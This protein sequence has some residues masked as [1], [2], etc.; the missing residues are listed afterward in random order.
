[1]LKYFALTAV[2]LQIQI[3][4][5]YANNSDIHKGLKDEQS[6]QLNFQKLKQGKISSQAKFYY[7]QA[8]NKYLNKDYK[9]AILNYTQAIKINP[10][11][12]D[13]YTGRG[14]AYR[15]LQDYQK[16]ILDCTQ[17]IKINPNYADAY[18]DRGSVFVLL[19]NYQKGMNDLNQAIKINPNDGLAYFYR[20]NARAALGD[21]QGFTEDADKSINI[22]T[23]TTHNLSGEIN[24]RMGRYEVAITEYN[25]AIEIDPNYAEAYYNR[26]QSSEKLGDYKGAVADYNQAANFFLEQG[27]MENHKKALQN[28]K[29]IQGR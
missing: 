22:K 10:N 29:R 12:A 19:K 24:F 14:L 21:F 25:Q 17:A 27:D 4:S 26:G 6:Y 9:G 28:I 1:M 15:S 5:V 16:A 11:Y 3:G 13:A 23:K 7:S 20:S 8:Q 18:R 2:L